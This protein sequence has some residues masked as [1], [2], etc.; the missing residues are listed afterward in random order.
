VVFLKKETGSIWKGGKG[1]IYG[2]TKRSQNIFP[3][4]DIILLVQ[5]ALKS[6][7]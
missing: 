1:D 7:E 4:S 3:V 5:I 2:S 6:N